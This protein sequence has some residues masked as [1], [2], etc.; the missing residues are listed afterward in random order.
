M[1]ESRYLRRGVSITATLYAAPLPPSLAIEKIHFCLL[2]TGRV[3]IF[4]TPPEGRQGRDPLRTL[5]TARTLADESMVGADIL[6][7]DFL[8]FDGARRAPAD[9]A[10]MWVQDGREFLPRI[11]RIDG[12]VVAYHPAAPGFP[13]LGGRPQGLGDAR[14]PA[15]SLRHRPRERDGRRPVVKIERIDAN[16]LTVSLEA[17]EAYRLALACEAAEIT[18]GGSVVEPAVFGLGLDGQDFGSDATVNLS[19]LY[20]G[21]HA[22]FMAGAVAAEDR[23]EHPVDW[24]HTLRRLGRYTA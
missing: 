10:I 21:L 2:G 1:S 24:A 11:A 17:G 4:L 13:V 8:V 7:G 9:G 3:G 22:A 16:E 18:L 20:A 23:M 15:A 5:Y 14:G 6:P 19:H 12:D